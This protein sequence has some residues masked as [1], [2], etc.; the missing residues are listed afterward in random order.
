[1]SHTLEL[2]VERLVLTGTD[3]TEGIGNTLANIITGND[4]ANKLS[5]LAG[6]DTLQGGLGQDTLTGGV[7]S[8]R[9]TGGD[10]ADIF[11]FDALAEKGDTFTDFVSGL[12]HIE[13]V[14]AGFTGAV[15]G[16][17]HFAQALTPHAADGNATFLFDTDASRLYWDDDGT[18]AHLAQLLATLTGVHSLAA[19]DLVIV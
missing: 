1:M 16:D 15:A 10:D 4:G 2:N 17:V 18:G 5:G 12:D 14:A 3:P 11:H 7:G 6:N 13:I 9:L 19:A 8:D